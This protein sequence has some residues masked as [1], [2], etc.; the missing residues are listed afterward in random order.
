MFVMKGKYNIAKIYLDE[1]DIDESTK[2]Q[3]QTFLNHPALS[4]SNIAI[5]PDCHAGKGAVVGFTMTMNEYII[6][7]LIGVD[8]GCSVLSYNLGKVDV[9]L[10]ELDKFFN[11]NI[12]S[13]FKVY[14]HKNP[15]GWV[16]E[17]IRELY[18]YSNHFTKNI[19]EI[20]QKINP[21]K[22]DYFFNS[23]GSLGS[24]NHYCE[25]GVDSSGNKW[26]TIHSGSRNFGLQ[27]ANYHQ[28][29]AV[30]L[31]K[32]FFKEEKDLAF[33]PMEYGGK[34]YL[35]DMAIAQKYASL[36]RRVM[37]QRIVN[38]FFKEKYEEKY[39]IESVHNYIDLDKKIIRKGAISAQE[40]ELVIIPFNMRDGMMIGRGK[41]NK[42]WNYS[43]PHGAGRSMSRK[44]AKNELTMDAF[45]KSMEGIYTT[46]AVESTLDEAPMAYKP[47]DLILKNI[48]DTVEPLTFVKPLWNFKAKEQE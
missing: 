6:A 7:N 28:A 48:A 40:N 11:E 27:I 1:V 30:A 10:S 16:D 43:A 12:P 22:E 2:V 24:G 25:L 5:M 4:H 46:S 14:N 19:S 42:D 17:R 41:G 32:R 47:M 9:D 44:Q 36:N 26:L 33:L 8:I 23:I 35:E 15:S 20:A 34:E 45:T 31:S 21:D 3:V 29:K 39:T 13:G 37:M 38:G 18:Q